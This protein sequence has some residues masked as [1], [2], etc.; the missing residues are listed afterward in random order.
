MTASNTTRSLKKS[1]IIL[2]AFP[3]TGGETQSFVHSACSNLPFP[4]TPKLWLKWKN[5][6]QHPEGD[7]LFS[8]CKY[9]SGKQE[10]GEV[11][12]LSSPETLM[13]NFQLN[14]LHLPFQVI[15]CVLIVDL[16]RAF[17]K[18][19]QIHSQNE[20]R[21]EQERLMGFKEKNNPWWR[22]GV[23]WI[24]KHKLPYVVATV[25]PQTP[26]ITVGELKDLLALEPTVPI[27]RCD[28]NLRPESFDGFYYPF[29][30]N[31]IEQVLLTLT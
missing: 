6:D 15:G 18:R 31:D 3:S 12:L 10:V 19:D 7:R 14:E 23:G 8:T 13:W 20:T 24:R 30:Q 26:A 11:T 21:L 2:S 1:I 22:G 25:E 4:R 28:L 5:A 17:Q 16:H 9:S 29:K 27:V